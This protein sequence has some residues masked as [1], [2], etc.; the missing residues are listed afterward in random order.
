MSNSVKK[1]KFPTFLLD[2]MQGNVILVGKL[3]YLAT[4]GNR[5]HIAAIELVS[6]GLGEVR[7]LKAISLI[8]LLLIIGN[9]LVLGLFIIA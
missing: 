2:M 9:L 3:L 4:V 7:P 6:A 5:Q 8:S 1:D